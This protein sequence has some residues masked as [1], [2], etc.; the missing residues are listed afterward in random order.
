LKVSILIHNL[1]RASALERCLLSIAEQEFRPLE[2][3][4]LDAGSTDNSLVVIERLSARFAQLHIDFRSV[5]C[6]P[7]GVAASRN[8]AARFASGDLLCVIDN[9]ACF[10]GAS[11]IERMVKGFESSPRL[12]VLS[13]RVLR[14][15]T[16]EFDPFS[17]VFRRNTNHWSHRTFRTFTFAGAGCCL[18]T[19]AFREVGGFWEQLKYSREEEDLALAL[20]DRDWQLEYSPEIVIRH[21]FDS[22]GRSSIFERRRIELRNGILVL[23]RR[24]PWPLAVRNLRANLHDVSQSSVTRRK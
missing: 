18:R 7:M 12:A 8:F 13:F 16:Q 10:V 19:S 11:C 9:D 15:D 2:V 21:Y 23:W 4:L 22:R 6:P 5:S 20:I 1:N 24:F 3:I 14:G 17:W